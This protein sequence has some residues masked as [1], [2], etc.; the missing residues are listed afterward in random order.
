LP[1][2]QVWTVGHA[3]GPA[4]IGLH[5]NDKAALRLRLRRRGEQDRSGSGEKRS[6]AR[7]SAHACAF[8]SSKI[9]HH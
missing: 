2:D 9:I 5:T 8:E 6:S 1:D 4:G 7:E 3:K